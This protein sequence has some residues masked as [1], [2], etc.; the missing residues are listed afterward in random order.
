MV[1]RASL[2]DACAGPLWRWSNT[3]SSFER[4][5]VWLYSPASD[6]KSGCVALPLNIYLMTD[7]ACST[8]LR[9][10]ACVCVGPKLC[11]PWVSAYF[12]QRVST[13]TSLNLICS[14]PVQ[15]WLG[16]GAWHMLNARVSPT[17]LVSVCACVCV[18]LPNIL[19]VEWRKS[20]FIGEWEGKGGRRVG[21]KEKEKGKK[22][23]QILH[24]NLNWIKVG[25]TQL[26]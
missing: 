6:T 25:L 20:V 12:S 8:W 7:G 2:P 14:G 5:C 13:S 26:K 16:P 22:T 9:A 24:F 4:V 11:H 1:A 21:G 18:F 23:K 3:L 15:V 19:F 17:I 10:W